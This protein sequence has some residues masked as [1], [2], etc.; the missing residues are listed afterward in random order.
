MTTTLTSQGKAWVGAART[1]GSSSRPPTMPELEELK[2]VY[3]K[4]HWILSSDSEL[5]AR[6]AQQSAI[7]TDFKYIFIIFLIAS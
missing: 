6:E 2:L 3:L 7:I 1:A 4:P 5:S